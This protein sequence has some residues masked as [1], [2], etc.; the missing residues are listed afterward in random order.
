MQLIQSVT[1]GS[2][3]AAS[4]ELGAGGTIPTTY[5]DLVILTSF[6]SAGTNAEDVYLQFNGDTGS[7]YS[8]R[9]LYGAGSGSGQSD[10]VS[11][12]ATAG[13]AS[14][15]TGGS[16]TSNTFS[17]DSI[18]IPNYRSSLAK[19]ITIDTVEENNA[20][21]SYQMVYATSWSGTTPIISIKLQI[22][23]GQNFAQNSSVSL[24]GVLKGS[25]GIVTVS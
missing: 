18:Y 1:V 2:G 17:N 4:I 15:A 16:Y 25:D 23:S 10:G 6:R 22:L 8:F 20:T 24:Y 14:R 13:R 9:R 5:T 7:N 11:G 21:A 3:G 19:T 12:A